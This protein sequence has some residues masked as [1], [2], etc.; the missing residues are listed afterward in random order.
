METTI[1]Y[2][3][4]VYQVHEFTD[5]NPHIEPCGDCCF[6]SKV[7]VGVYPHI[8]KGK[9]VMVNECGWSCR[10]PRD[11][12]RCTGPLRKDGRNVY[13]TCFGKEAKK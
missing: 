5:K 10:K 12:E 2:K 3:G 1:N 7:S 6:G 13:F 11:F 9:V 8:M 4:T